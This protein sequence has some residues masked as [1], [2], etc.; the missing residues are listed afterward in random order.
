[1]ID[2][3]ALDRAVRRFPGI[4]GWAKAGTPQ[5]FIGPAMMDRIIAEYR[6][7]VAKE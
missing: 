6:R 7:I 4:V 5:F 1:M 3:P 2:E